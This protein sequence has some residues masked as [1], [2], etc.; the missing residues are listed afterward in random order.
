MRLTDRVIPLV[1]LAIVFVLMLGEA[2]LSRRHERALRAR[3][4]VEPEGDVY[5]VMRVAYPLCFLAVGVEGALAGS[6]PRGR[7]LA[8]AAVFVMA[9]A[10]KYWAIATLGERWTFRVLVLPGVPLVTGGPYRWLNHPNYLAVAGEIA[11]AAL[12]LRAPVAGLLGLAGFGALIRRRIA[13]EDRALAAAR[14]HNPSA[15]P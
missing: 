15:G 14:R 3:G 10:L 11:G 9:K 8:G 1:V 5:P 4:A 2:V 13:V 12:M 7:L 6:P